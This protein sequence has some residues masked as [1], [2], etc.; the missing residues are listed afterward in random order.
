MD[1][2]KLLEQMRDE[3]YDEG[4]EYA[5]SEGMNLGYLAMSLMILALVIFN[6]FV[7]EN[8]YSILA[9]SNTFIAAKAYSHYK[10]LKDKISKYTCIIAGI[11]SALFLLFHIPY[12]LEK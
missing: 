8:S 12:A 5:E 7:H 1:K 2:E 3:G 11:A 6:L 10:V 4:L 9:L